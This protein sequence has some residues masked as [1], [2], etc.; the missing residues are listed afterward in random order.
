MLRRFMLALPLLASAGVSTAQAQSCD[1]RF[2]FN[3]RSSVTVMEF[4]FDSSR[5]P[6]W[7]R[8]ELGSGV[9]P[10]GQSRRFAAAYSGMYDFRAVL[11]GGRAVEL[12]Q[13]NIC[14][15]TNVTLTNGGLSAQ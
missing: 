15:I 7:T 11:Q 9:L 1:T 5:N 10:P 2:V 14:Q 6:R 13:V 12:R 4:Y 3:N 8:D